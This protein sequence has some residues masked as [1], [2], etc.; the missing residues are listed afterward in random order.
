M[1]RYQAGDGGAFDGLVELLGAPLYR[2][3]LHSAGGD[4]ASADDLYQDTWLKLHEARKSFRPGEA[5]MP[6]LFGIARH[7]LLD[8][9]RRTARHLR[10]VGALQRAGDAASAV[11]PQAPAA[12]DLRAETSQLLALAM[13][14][15]PDNQREA[16]FL[17][18]V[19]GLSVDE[20]AEIVGV[21]AGALKVRAHRAY[22]RV[23]AR[24][25]ALSGRG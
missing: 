7:V 13:V 9:R 21:R 25:A 5:V 23:R 12:A 1:A 15:L 2:F 11:L 8:H 6:W 4:R 18:K 16:L 3:L 14:D 10:R 22:E 17:L 24:L 19:E 20:A